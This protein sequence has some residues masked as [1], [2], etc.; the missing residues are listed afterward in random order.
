[1]NILLNKYFCGSFGRV[2]ILVIARIDLFAEAAK[3][4][5]VRDERGRLRLV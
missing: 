2:D 1:M 4:F 3:I 5:D